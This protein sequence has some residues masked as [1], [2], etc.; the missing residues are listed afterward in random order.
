MPPLE[1]EALIRPIRL[2]RPNMRDWRCRADAW[3]KLLLQVVEDEAAIINRVEGNDC[4]QRFT[5]FKHIINSS[6]GT[7][8]S[9]MGR[10]SRRKM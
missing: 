9:K 6:D 3:N 4:F 2:V 1:P 10:I 5:H 8:L 7:V